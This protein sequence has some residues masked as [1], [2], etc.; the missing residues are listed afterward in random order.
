MQTSN[1]NLEK[2]IAVWY[3]DTKTT[4]KRFKHPITLDEAIEIGKQKGYGEQVIICPSILPKTQITKSIKDLING[5]KYGY[6]LCCIIQFSLDTLRNLPIQAT[7]RYTDT[8][9][10]VPCNLHI[11]NCKKPIPEDTF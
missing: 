3:T 1:L 9:D 7:L 4:Y 10:Y 11:R 8:V 2:P 5:I 6:P